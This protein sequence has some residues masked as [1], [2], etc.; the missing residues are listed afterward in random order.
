M[1][2]GLGV[3]PVV[4]SAKEPDDGMNKTERAFWQHLN[5][6]IVNC[7]EVRQVSREPVKF[8]LAGRTWYTP[9]FVVTTLEP[10][11]REFW[12]IE[13]KGF[14]RDDASVKLKVAAETYPCFRWLL[15]RRAGRHGWSVREVGRTG[16]GT[17]EIVVPW[18]GGGA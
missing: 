9:D 8:R 10:Q 17:H 2:R 11:G 6:A 4:P 5:L 15:V 14:M 3:E 7:K 13:I 12:F 1:L 16:I 18:I